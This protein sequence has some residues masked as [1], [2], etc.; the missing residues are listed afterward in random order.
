MNEFVEASRA[1]L[2][3]FDAGLVPGDV[4]LDLCVVGGAVMPLT[5]RRD[6]ES[7]RPRAIF[8]SGESALKARR[9]AAARSGVALDRLEDAARRFVAG[10]PEP[11]PTFEGERL[12]AFA[13]PA[14]YLLAMK[15]AALGFGQDGGVED[16]IRY[17]LRFLGLRTPQAALATV[18]GYLN[19]RQRPHD[20]ESRL[21]SILR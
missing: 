5:F 11:G 17:L 18:S 7:R 2:R 4:G 16:D 19:P 15:C 14:D 9:E 13:P 3:R 8:A 10:S 6:P 20:L 21:A 12:T 1:I